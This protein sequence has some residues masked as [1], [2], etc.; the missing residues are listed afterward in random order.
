LRGATS[1]SDAAIP[2]PTRLFHLF[3]ALFF[4][5]LAIVTHRLAFLLPFIMVAWWLIEN[6][7]TRR[8]WR[9]ALAATATLAA[10]LVVADLT[11]GRHFITHALGQLSLHYELPYYLSFLLREYW[12]LAA[13][14]LY[15][16]FSAQGQTRR[17]ITLLFLPFFAYLLSLSFLTELV[18][19]RY[20]F[21]VTL[22]LYA[23]SAWAIVDVFKKIRRPALKAAWVAAV[24]ATLLASGT[25]IVAPREFYWLEADD[26]AKLSGRPH[27]AYTPQPDWNDAY[28]FVKRER[29]PSDIVISSN[30]VFTKIFLGEPGYWIQYDYLG[31][32]KSVDY[33]VADKEY[34]V[35]AETIVGLPELMNL[36]TGRHGFLVLDYMAA[37]GKLDAAMQTH[38]QTN[39]QLVYQ[40]ELNSYSKI[41]IYR[42]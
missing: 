42:F 39:L 26:P 15:A 20:L 7:P 38:I 32:E 3:L 2:P 29:Q 41:W 25:A 14:S 9:T 24:A 5:A 13:L 30:P 35:N 27:Y 10:F 19:Y 21:P 12:P 22:P 28:A 6:P 17:V 31:F 40:R 33:V 18:Q 4:T 11:F 8:S 37:D 36:T 34:Y 16:F 23:A 1:G